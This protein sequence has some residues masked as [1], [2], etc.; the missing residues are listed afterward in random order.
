MIEVVFRYDPSAP[1]EVPPGSAAEAKEVLE[2]GNQRFARLADLDVQAG[3]RVVLP[4]D[5]RDFGVGDAMGAAPRQEPFAAVLGCADA[6]VPIEIVFEQGCNDLFVVR[7]AG[8]VVGSECLGSLSYA[9]HHFPSLKLI[10]VLGH[11]HC[12]AV[13]A[14]VDSYLQPAMY[15]P[16][17]TNYPLQSIVNRILPA[18][19]TAALA[20]R[21]V[22]GLG[23]LSNPGYRAA[24]VET[25]V[26][27]NA[28]WAAYSLKHE[29][30]DREGGIEVVFAVYDLVSRYAR[31]PLEVDPAVGSDRGLFKP[32]EDQA[33]FDELGG[34]VAGGAFVRSLLRG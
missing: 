17:A 11:L 16:L 27:M 32:P 22:H 24:L 21:R 34:R 33:G 5:L 26:V 1:P 7:V 29:V 23:V 20:L 10:L 12:G 8:N 18:V 4:M 15:L 3:E 25:S 28:A 14:A 9:S 19:R 2:R 30:A 13:T 6:R 31:L